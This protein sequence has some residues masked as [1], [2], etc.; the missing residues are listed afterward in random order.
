MV[1]SGPNAGGKTVTLKA[2]GLNQL[3]LQSGMLIPVRDDSKMMI[4]NKIMIDI[5]EQQSIEGDLST[6]SSRLLN[7]KFFAEKS[8]RN[9]LILIDEFGSGSDPKMGGAIAEAVLHSI[10][11]RKCMGIITTHYSNIKNYA[12]KSPNIVNGA[13]LFDKDELQPTFKLKVGQ[14]GSSF[15]YEIADKIGL[16]KKILNY[17][18]NLTGKKNNQV[19]KLLIEL[20]HEKKV[21]ED[22]LL[23]NYDESY[24]LNKLIKNYESMKDE[25]SIRRK[26]L[27]LEAK[28]KNYL[29]L[30]DYERELQRLI[31]EVKK[32]KNTEKAKVL[33][34]DIKNKRKESRSNIQELTEE[35]FQKEIEEV[36][37]LKVGQ[38]VKLRSGGDSGKVISFTDR[39]VAIE[40]GIM[41]FEVP[42]SEIISANEPLKLK[43]KTI[44]TDTVLNPQT[45]ETSLDIRG[46]SKSEAMDSMQ[47]FL[48][49]ALMSSVLQLKILHGK[50]SGV[51]KKVVW[52]KAK[53]YKDIKKIWHPTDD[54]GGQGVTYISF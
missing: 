15:A 35:V 8:D 42:R 52:G 4:F 13:M 31:S 19:D 50:G 37:D 29:N 27:K 3:M 39:K 23:E 21:L 10:V 6:Y 47:E 17:A 40:M 53:E 41:K 2:L 32:E 22:K 14:P 18:K 16:P 49:N 36:K 33:L 1:I 45:I 7:M 44:V 46:Y 34:S 30:S 20:Q 51:L 43:T 25:L 9:S 5:G 12:F 24:R 26:K 48:D 54:F 38:F 11:N 28:E